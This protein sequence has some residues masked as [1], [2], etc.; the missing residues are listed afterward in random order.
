MLA[1]FYAQAAKANVK[2]EVVFVSRDK[3][4]G[5]M[6]DYLA[7]MPWL[8]LAYDNPL[9][10]RLPQMFQ[11]NGIPH[12]KVFS[13]QGALLDNDAVSKMSYENLKKWEAGVSTMAPQDGGGHSHGGGGGCCSGG[14]CH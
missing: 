14:G 2:F 4:E 3:S 10:D 5:E 12:L 11:V 1:N 6:R 8:A 13:S 7:E 9:R